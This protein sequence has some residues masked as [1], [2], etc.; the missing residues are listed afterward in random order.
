MRWLSIFAEPR[1]LIVVALGWVFFGGMLVVFGLLF[2][3]IIEERAADLQGLSTEERFAE[4]L[5]TLDRLANEVLGVDM[6]DEALH[7][8]D[9][10]LRNLEAIQRDEDAD[11]KT[12]EAAA[13]LPRHLED[14]KIGA[15]RSQIEGG[16]ANPPPTAPAAARPP[17][18]DDPFLA[19]NAPRAPPQGVIP[20]WAAAAG[21]GLAILAFGGLASL[22][23]LRSTGSAEG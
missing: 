1:V 2:G 23:V 18:S 15:I 17:P 19:R 8:I 5:K 20:P 3:G 22:L 9:A 10:Q 14:A 11:P 21:C 12:K 16:P 7:E 4:D 6:A 13:Q